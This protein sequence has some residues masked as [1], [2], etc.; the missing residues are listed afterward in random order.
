[1][2]SDGSQPR[3]YSDFAAS[4]FYSGRVGL[5]FQRSRRPHTLLLTFD[6]FGSFVINVIDGA[7]ESV[8]TNACI[9]KHD[10]I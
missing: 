1:M 6:Y 7:I 9:N 2:S 4:A 3:S 10:S 5:I 8:V